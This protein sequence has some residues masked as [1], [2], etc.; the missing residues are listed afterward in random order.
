M[1]MN[2]VKSV[3]VLFVS[4]SLSITS[5]AQLKS[6]KTQALQTVSQLQKIWVP[7]TDDREL[8]VEYYAP[9]EGEPT[10]VLLN[11][12]T[13]STKQWSNFIEP[14]VQRGVGVVS[15]DFEGQG[16]VLLR[17]A[18]VVDVIPYTTQVEHL[19]L[20]LN[21]MKIKKPYNLLGLSYGAG[22]AVAYAMQYPSSVNQLILMAPYTKPLAN[23]DNW[24]RSQIWATRTIFPFINWTEDE[25]YD[26]Y[27]KQIVYATYPQ[28]EPVVLEN[29]FKLE[30]TFRL[31]QGIRKFVP[32]NL[33]DS[34]KV[35]IHL[36]VARNDQYIPQSDLDR[37]WDLL[38][39]KLKMS[40][41]FV[42]NSE[43]KIPEAF[44]NFSSAWTYQILKGNSL[45]FK[46]MDFEG[47]PFQGV[48][49]SAD[50]SVVL[51]EK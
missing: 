22:I 31:A 6:K 45:L 29:P 41:L 21:N 15:F 20:L 32:E 17:Y 11:G 5:V 48:A 16:R 36:V 46:S 49:K 2:F 39:G 9:R 7:I 43:H 10:V 35:P 33:T 3:I 26:Y 37:Y 13:Y 38:P 30:A 28:Y 34:L 19:N 8:Y 47:Y 14:L 50:G 23:L 51:G 42:N 1:S 27:Y 40:R 24:I 25:M 12:L 18:P 4:M 44:P